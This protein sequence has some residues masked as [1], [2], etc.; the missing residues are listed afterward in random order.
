MS[1]Q[2]LPASLRAALADALVLG[3]PDAP[4][5]PPAA[6]PHPSDLRRG[7]GIIE[8]QLHPVD[9]KHAA[10]CLAKLASG[11]NERLTKEEAHLR[12]EVWLETCGDIPTD[13]WSSATVDLL[14]SWKRDDHYGRVPE[15][16]DLRARAQDQMARRSIE[17][18]RCKAMLRATENPAD[19]PGA[20]P[21]HVP[22]RVR[23]KRIRDE[24]LS[25]TEHPYYLTNA[26]NTERCLALEEKRPME[27]WAREHF[28]AKETERNRS[29]SVGA[30]AKAVVKAPD[31]PGMLRARARYWRSQGRA[32]FADELDSQADAL[33]PRPP[34]PAAGDA[35]DEQ[36]GHVR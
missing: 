12:L 31:K 30:Q 27:R 24:W 29:G 34:P 21:I 10:F 35:P 20:G 23:L 33:A 15:A 28:D 16:A 5:Q 14:R 19:K 1:A 9:R 6:L 3:H 11:F 18:Q 4:W 22:E 13:L 2:A 32:E 36:Y 17:L 26:A 8:A 7:I 25:R